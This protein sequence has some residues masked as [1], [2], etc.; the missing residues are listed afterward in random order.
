[1][2]SDQIFL[3]KKHSCKMENAELGLMQM[4]TTCKS[5]NGERIGFTSPKEQTIKGQSDNN[6][7]VKNF[8]IAI[9]YNYQI[10]DNPMVSDFIMEL[11]EITSFSGIAERKKGDMTS[12][13]I[14]FTLPLNNPDVI[15]Y[16]NAEN[17]VYESCTQAC[18][19][20]KGTL[21]RFNWTAESV[22][23]YLKH[24][25]YYPRDGITG[26]II[27]GKDPS[28]YLDLF[29]YKRGPYESKTLFTDLDSNNVEW[30]LLKNA[31]IR[32]VPLVNFQRIFVGT[33]GII[34]R[35]IISAVITHV[36]AINSQS[37]QT[38]TIRRIV[39]NRPELKNMVAA[40]IAKLSIDRQS[41]LMSTQTPYGNSSTQVIPEQPT[42][43]GLQPVAP[44][45]VPHTPAPSTLQSPP[46]LQSYQIPPTAWTTNQTGNH[47]IV[48]PELKTNTNLYNT[49]TSMDSHP[50][51][52][53]NSSSMGQQ[54]FSYP[55]A[56][57]QAP[58]PTMQRLE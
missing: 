28:T 52:S 41:T 35:V 45:V 27:K 23:T 30:D 6:N 10:T 44:I 38:A 4:Q 3:K 47:N 2:C 58:P 53:N 33:V 26:E 32:M 21:K 49:L 19:N 14:L 31:E 5:F 36:Q 55:F 24:P 50:Q 1:M 25:I 22:R 15:E 18:T 16:I 8:N 20:Y 57:N 29:K 17:V 39:E 43:S 54:T 12:Y 11:P 7:Q 13:S 9:N 51:Y 42:C 34:R 40:Q 56:G 48:V 37:R 46:N